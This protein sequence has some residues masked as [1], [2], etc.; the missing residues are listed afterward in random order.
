[1][2]HL[3][4]NHDSDARVPIQRLEEKF[5][6][7]ITSELVQE[8][9]IGI[10]RQCLVDEWLDNPSEYAPFIRSNEKKFEDMAKEFLTPGH[11]ASE[12]GN[13]MPMAMANVLSL[14]IAILTMMQNM[15]IILV[16]PRSN[17]ASDVPICLAR[18]EFSL[19]YEHTGTGYYDYLIRNDINTNTAPLPNAAQPSLASKDIRC[20]C[21]QGAKKQCASFESCKDYKS[22]CLCFRGL[23]AVQ[24][25]AVA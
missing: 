24:S 7:V 5:P 3:N 13:S 10:L 19:A 8:N 14:P 4:K 20:R 12:I 1:M 2:Y 6:I 11:F 16:T 15:S 21:A 22:R 23:P 9:M 25:T 18:R 17:V